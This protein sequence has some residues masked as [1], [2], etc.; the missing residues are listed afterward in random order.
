MSTYSMADIVSLTGIKAHTLRKWETRYNFLEPKRTE[1]NIRFY[2]DDQLRMLLNIGILLRNGHRISHIDKMS[3]G[4]IN[5]TV[6]EILLEASPKD[7]I[8]A[9]ILCMLE[10]N[11]VRFSEIL[12]RHI[13]RSGL[14]K[15]ITNLVYP[16]LNHV[17]VL[18]GTNKAMP[19]QEHFI[20]N[21]IKQKIL[22][23]IEA[24][25]HPKDS[26]PKIV[27]F[28]MEEETHEIGLLLAYYLAKELGWK[29]F[30]LGQ[31]VPQEDLKAVLQ[32]VRPQLMMTLLTLSRP[33]KT[34]DLITTLLNS[35]T[36]PIA[37]A[38]SAKFIED[39]EESDQV[40]VL[41]NPEEFI[42]LLNEKKET[43]SESIGQAIY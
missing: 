16:F 6:S 4:E 40:I 23:A 17:G 8:N 22:S 5:N 41:N 31:N 12:G 42:T 7:D 29:T 25:P 3:Q 43:P 21:L 38:G 19:A 32:L 20:S 26:A 15:T 18:W 28:L 10:M 33:Q 39:V 11:E 30:Y 36:T 1:T 2:T 37:I 35:T 9:L 34:K 24:I 27:L 13:M 14:I